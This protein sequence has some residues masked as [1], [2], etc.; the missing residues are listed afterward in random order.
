MPISGYSKKNTPSYL[1]YTLSF[2]CNE[3]YLY[4]MSQ[5]KSELVNM[6]IYVGQ[7]HRAV[8]EGPLACR[9]WSNLRKA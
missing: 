9:V 3:Q 2:H 5:G 6:S 4:L 7:T 8:N 1:A